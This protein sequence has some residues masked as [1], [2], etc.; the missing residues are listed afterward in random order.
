M[1]KLT[2]EEA[3]HLGR[4]VRLPAGA[5]AVRVTDERGRVATVVEDRLWALRGAGP[6]EKAVAGVV[7]R[8]RGL[9]NRPDLATFAAKRKPIEVVR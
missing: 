4:L 6:F 7:A 9:T 3:L 8:K 2:V 1:K 5:N